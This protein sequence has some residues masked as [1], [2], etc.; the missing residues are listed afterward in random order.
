MVCEILELVNKKGDNL[1]SNFMF[2]I[3][4]GNYNEIIQK[5]DYEIY[6][7]Y[8]K[9]SFDDK[10]E[11]YLN[12]DRYETS[13]YNYIHKNI[14]DIIKTNIINVYSMLTIHEIMTYIIETNTNNKISNFDNEYENI[15]N[16]FTLNAID[17]LNIKDIDSK[18]HDIDM[19]IEEFIKLIPNLNQDN[20]NEIS[21]IIQNNK[22][23]SALMSKLVYKD[24]EHLL[25]NMK[26]LSIIMK[27]IN[28]LKN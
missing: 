19:L 17:K 4:N 12:L 16:I 28:M 7:K 24:I 15:K 5:G 18:P 2:K 10:Y 8:L 1:M 26:K 27:M 25:E 6:N 3:L 13:D 22:D 23:L 14:L 11:E 9:Y 21:K 20:V